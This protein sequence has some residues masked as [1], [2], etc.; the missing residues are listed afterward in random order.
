MMEARWN[1]IIKAFSNVKDA[2]CSNTPYYGPAPGQ[3]LD[4]SEVP[5]TESGGTQIGLPNMLRLQ[6][7]KYRGSS[8]GHVSF[9]PIVASRG[10][11]VLDF[12]RVSKKRSAE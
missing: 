6:S 1:E 8:G 12:Y 7:I 10:R 3:L 11:D 4:A 9:S 5:V 2:R